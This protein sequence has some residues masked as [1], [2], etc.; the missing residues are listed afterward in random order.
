VK[1]SVAIE[2]Q[3]MF[4]NVL[5]RTFLNNPDSGNARATLQRNSNGTTLSGF[6]RINTG[7]VA[8]SPRE[9]VLSLRVRF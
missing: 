6:G 7:S 8:A 4:F 3:A 9:G 5:N 2:L 1:E